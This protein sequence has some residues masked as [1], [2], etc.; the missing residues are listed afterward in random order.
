MWTTTS[1]LEIADEPAAP[2]G[3]A[4]RRRAG[5][6][7][8]RHCLPRREGAPLRIAADGRRLCPDALAVPQ[9]GRL[10]GSGDPGPRPRLGPRD[11]GFWSGAIVGD[12]RRPDRLPQ[13][14][15]PVP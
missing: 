7:P 10:A 15:L 1:A 2:P 8:D 13:L 6:D 9:F 12:R 4:R 14:V 11:W 3:P 5:L